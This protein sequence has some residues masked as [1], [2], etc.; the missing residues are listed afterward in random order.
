M[1]YLTTF[2]LVRNKSSKLRVPSCLCYLLSSANLPDFQTRRK[3]PRI[4]PNHWRTLAGF[5][6]SLKVHA[7]YPVNDNYC[8]GVTGFMMKIPETVLDGISS[9]VKGQ[10]GG[11]RG[12]QACLAAA[13]P[14]LASRLTHP[15]CV[16]CA[17]V[18]VWTRIT[19]LAGLF[20]FLT[21]PAIP[22]FQQTD[23]EAL[24]NLPC[25][26]TQPEDYMLL[27]LTRVLGARTQIPTLAQ[28]ALQQLSHLPSPKTVIFNLN[29]SSLEQRSHASS[30]GRWE[31]LRMISHMLLL[32]YFR[33]GW[34]WESIIPMDHIIFVRFAKYMRVR[35]IVILSKVCPFFGI[36]VSWEN[37][38][39][40]SDINLMLHLCSVMFF[41]PAHTP[42][43]TLGK[44]FE[45][46]LY[47][48]NVF[49][50]LNSLIL[51]IW[52]LQHV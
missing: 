2:N 27:G 10:M 9:R 25:P 37:I 52:Y 33:G 23:K 34:R 4:S 15:V 8:L 26:L 24:G 46:V 35:E 51:Y 3:K 20:F 41:Q 29:C 32:Y 17:Y 50:T 12:D 5:V 19:C 1:P 36:R 14:P 45:Q 43:K 22:Q 47:W 44:F 7:I 42:K 21:G 13:D 38:C 39:F 48:V 18:Q 30:A 11:M 28:Q 49:A 40:G 16:A 31:S 6:R